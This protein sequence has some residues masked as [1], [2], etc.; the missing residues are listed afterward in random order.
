MS[1][2]RYAPLAALTISASAFAT[3][4]PTSVFGDSYIVVDGARTFSV[5]DVYI[6]CGNA[7]DII[8]STFGTAGTS[9]WASSYT[10]NNGKSFAQSNGNGT[11]SS[12][13]PAAGTTS[14]PRHTLPFVPP[15]PQK[16]AEA[17]PCRVEGANC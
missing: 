17:P 5:M 16:L 4:T 9:G 11:N 6:K 12:W 2:S 14:T 15:T 13:L 1:A 3:V 8:S 10:L 7:N